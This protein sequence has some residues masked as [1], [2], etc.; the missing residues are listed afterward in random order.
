MRRLS[1]RQWL[2]VAFCATLVAAFAAAGRAS[3]RASAI[4]VSPSVC[5]LGR[6]DSAQLAAAPVLSDGPKQDVTSNPRT[7]WSSA[8]TNAA[9]VS[10]TGMVT[11]TNTGVTTITATFD[12]ASASVVCTVSP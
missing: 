5:A 11:G 4:A 7:R 2:V 10:D 3:S 12:G 9:T 6:G 1:R 8:N